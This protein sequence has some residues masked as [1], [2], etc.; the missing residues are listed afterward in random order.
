MPLLSLTCGG[1]RALEDALL[2]R[3][4]EVKG[5][6]VAVVS[7]GLPQ[8][9]RLQGL[10]LSRRGGVAAG[11][12][13]LP[14]IPKLA[15]WL[16]G[17]GDVMEKPSPADR[18]AA[19]MRA[20]SDLPPNAPFA[21]LA[22]SPRAVM[23]LSDFFEGL[24]ERG[25]T[26][27]M[28]RTI[29]M[30]LSGDNQL[31]SVVAGLFE[32]YVEETSSLYPATPASVTES[33]TARTVPDGLTVFLYGFYDLSPG[34]RRLVRRLASSGARMHVLTPLTSS[35][36]WRETFSRTADLLF[37]ELRPGTVS[38]PLADPEAGP[39]TD[40]A[41]AAVRGRRVPA[42]YGGRSLRV[43]SAAGV[44]GEAR[45]IVLEVAR[46]RSSGVEA[47]DIAV[48]ARGGVRDTAAR[49]AG[50]EGIPVRGNRK[51][52]L[53]SLPACR[54]LQQLMS[55][56]ESEFHYRTL[57]SV[58]ETGALADRVNPGVSG[59]REAV[60]SSGVRFGREAW[61]RASRGLSQR[62]SHLIEDLHGFF[63]GLPGKDLPASY[64]E[65]IRS[66]LL[67]LVAEG[68]GRSVLARE[69]DGL[70]IRCRRPVP[71]RLF[72]EMLCRE[73]GG[74]TASAGGGDPLGVSFL[75]PEEVRGT[76]FDAVIFAGLNESE[77]PRLARE[78][79]RLS[80]EMREKLQ[81]HPPEERYSEEAYLFTRV[82]EAAASHLSLV[83]RSGS[84]S[85]ESMQPSPFISG[86]VSDGGPETAPPRPWLDREAVGGSAFQILLG[87]EGWLAR[88][89]RELVLG[90]RSPGLPFFGRALAA[91][92]ARMSA[93]PFDRY[94][95]VIGPRDGL[96][97]TSATAMEG[98][99][100]CP[101]KYMAEN[102]WGLEERPDQGVK[103]ALN[104]MDRG[105]LLHAS[106]E[107]A[108][109]G[110]GFTVKESVL[111]GIVE[112]ELEELESGRAIG[113]PALREAMLD[114]E[115]EALHRFIARHGRLG[116]EV[117]DTEMEV[118]GEYGEVEVSRG[119]IDLVVRGPGG[120]ELLDF[121][122]GSSQKKSDVRKRLKLGV[123]MQ[124]AL[125][126]DLYRRQ[127]GE[128]ARGSGYVYLEAAPEGQAVI[129]APDID[130]ALP[131]SRGFAAAYAR[132][133][134]EGYF[135]PLPSDELNPCRYCGFAGLCRKLPDWRRERRARADSRADDLREG[136]AEDG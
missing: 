91:E 59:V 103:G 87:G 15:G 106:L 86:L 43:V 132:L 45:A 127:T 134:G 1:F 122:T 120:I 121:K 58:C 42:P 93:A 76:S 105:R 21:G 92:S 67:P 57:E 24:L 47:R 28:Y 82:A 116:W 35:S 32:E 37:E 133:M 136:G 34:Q 68:E 128:D 80:P 135:P 85:G 79:P 63:S 41:S 44:L 108:L 115:T 36:A 30:S 71:W 99:A 12:R 16:S 100:C 123:L 17:L 69:L 19:C 95:G 18:L 2:E 110:P 83:W 54:L 74:M 23:S 10:L 52:P 14:G 114:L 7:G 72:S 13:F 117:L 78:D 94:D 101:F 61:L 65:R 66:R 50:E 96:V 129:A 62:M 124:A 102:V 27:E 75:S 11:I 3:L 97:R 60:S 89:I 31:E 22:A 6:R 126:L 109:E 25:V 40:T 111:R 46:L 73:L 77:F 84:I 9:R 20:V 49:L 119:K 55:L 48:A 39:F 33:V 29:T 5:G 112:E 118:S 56:D 88:A 131:A 125:Y 90:G 64:L 104:P 51:V 113:S 8:Q 107:R 53:D 70:S 130:E 4:D 26:P 38:H 98:Y 81:L